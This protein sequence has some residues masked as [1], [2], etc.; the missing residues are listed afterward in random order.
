M[1]TK[2]KPT[3]IDLFAGA[4]GF[5]LGFQKAGFE[6]IAAVEIDKH[7]C[8]TL[9][10]NKSRSFPKMQII[11]E[12]ITKLSGK[13]LMKKVG[14]KKGELGMLI[15]GPPCQGFTLIS[16][17]RSLN[18]PRSKLMHEF[19]RMV[20][21]IQPQ[22]FMVEN[23]PGMFAYKDF[24]ILLM[25]LLEKCGYIVRCLMMDAVSYGV[26]QY[27]R[28][29][30]IQGVRKDLDFLP[31]F[32]PPENFDPEQ[33]KGEGWIPPAAIAVKCFA[34]NGFPKEEVKNLWW[35]KKLSIQINKKK[36]AEQ[37]NQAINLIIAEGIK[38]CL[39]ERKGR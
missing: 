11:Q 34:M 25:K 28:R 3:C 27:R 4:G 36:A 22:M 26:P 37:I 13:D 38:N 33:L 39:E 16:R 23:V 30:F 31:I 29:I 14:I 2:K 32:P 12:N 6:I 21:E 15:G 8:A 5:S 24:F 19:I 17:K 10:A 18:D 20:N 35:N 9:R 1:K 7:A